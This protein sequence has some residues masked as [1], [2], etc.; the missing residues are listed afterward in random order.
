MARRLPL[1]PGVLAAL[2]AFTAL[3]AEEPPLLA[4]EV[5]AGRLPPLA[6]R[7]PVVPRRDV[8]ARPDWK[9]GRYGGELRTLSRG[10][11]DP[12]DLVILGYARLVAWELDDAGAFRLVPDIL[13]SIEVEAGRAFTLR[14]RPGHR[15]SDG[16][17]FTAEDFRFWWQDIA[18]DPELSPNGPPPELLVDGEPPRFEVLDATTLRFTWP[19][20]NSRFLPALA[21]TSP[22]FIYAPA[23]YLKPF[24]PRHAA[25]A[26]LEAAAEAA[27]Q[28]NW[29]A[30]F[31]RL[32][33]PFR[34]D[35]PERPTL[36]PWINTTAPPAERFV[37]RRNPYFHRVDGAGR[38]LPYI[39]R[40]IVA[41]TQAKLIPAQAAA[42]AAGL[43]A[44]GLSLADFTLLKQ[45]E[46]GGK[47][48]VRLWPIGRG[49]QL[50][51]YPNLNA[52]DADW[53]AL[54]RQADFRRALSL[55]VDRE[56]INQVIYQ[57]LARPGGNG[58]LPA[59]PLFAPGSDWARF[60]PSEA[61]RL[62]DGLGLA[63][64]DGDGIRLM[65]SGRRLEL[66]V[67]TGETDPA[68]VD[69][70]ELIAEQWRAVGVEMLI[71]ATGRQNFRNRVQSGQTAMSVFYGLANGLASA[72][73]S[74]AE[75][76]PT[77]DR[78]NNWPLWGL[79]FQT[80]GR[81]GE[82]PDLPEASRLLA[83]YRD[84]SRAPDA[85]GRGSAW[86]E[87]LALHADQVFTIGLI[88][89]VQ[90]PVVSDVKLRNLPQRAHYLYNPGAYFGIYRP[91]TFWIE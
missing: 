24:H 45:A 3:A 55:A 37:G 59:S 90:Q 16:H 26:E 51:L 6:E 72:D 43:Q 10:G 33:R 32:D 17:A 41:R 5:A 53:R 46:A 8:P 34:F 30:R 28:R 69:I 48:K 15:W 9:P 89:Q 38:Q 64:R 13:E 19:A 21:A 62:L 83:L 78:Q 44:R 56:Q 66:V 88:G 29:A 61:N 84:W 20:P 7:L 23:H 39:D 81:G 52:A 1:I 27:G 82:A 76:A 12:R 4:E 58:V 86:R 60:D 36:Q 35:N 80:S 71:R 73:M 65:A 54:L 67:E 68:E 22:R 74:P 18:N 49:A 87:M 25:R 47:I 63:A 79:H 31:Q 11:R 70:L 50:A 91:D 77:S 42:G 40:V 85:A 2:F 57:G 75:L 14:L